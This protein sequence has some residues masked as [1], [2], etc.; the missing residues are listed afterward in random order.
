V[1]KAVQWLGFPHSSKNAAG[2]GGEC[3]LIDPTGW[4]RSLEQYPA[5]TP[6]RQPASSAVSPK[7]LMQLFH[8][9]A[10]FKRLAQSSAFAEIKLSIVIIY[11]SPA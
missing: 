8:K 1:E 7:E 4:R 2:V 6:G 10:S 3:F 9:G 11:R 5:G